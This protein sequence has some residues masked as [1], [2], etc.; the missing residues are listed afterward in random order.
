MSRPMVQA[1]NVKKLVAR[2]VITASTQIIIVADHT[3]FI[4]TAPFNMCNL[5]EIDML[6]S[7]KAPDVK[8][9]RGLNNANIN[10]Y[11]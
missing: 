4:R 3:K 11:L 9:K 7:D 8:F 6:A 5:S 10:V 1:G 2:A